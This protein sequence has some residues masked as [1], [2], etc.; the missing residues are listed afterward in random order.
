M[1]VTGGLGTCIIM[2]IAKI[3]MHLEVFQSPER[4]VVV[5][6]EAVAEYLHPVAVV[7]ARDGLHQVAKGKKHR[8]SNQF[9]NIHSTKH[10]KSECREFKKFK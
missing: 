5:R 10:G 1:I 4:C 2:K 6:R 3:H 9:P 7:H 8:N